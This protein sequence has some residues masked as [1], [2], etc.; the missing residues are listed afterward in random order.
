VPPG[1]KAA[2][3][4]TGPFVVKI[5][6]SALLLAY[7]LRSG[8][9]DGV[10][11]RLAATD[12]GWVWAGFA[13]YAGSHLLN[14]FRWDAYARQFGLV[15]RTSSSIRFYFTGLFLNLFAPGT[16]VGDLSRGIALGRGQRRGVALASVVAHRLTGLVALMAIGGV[17]GLLQRQ[18]ELGWALSLACWAVP[19][20]SVAG[21]FFLPAVLRRGGSLLGREMVLPPAWEAATATTLSLAVIYHCAQILSVICLARALAIGVSMVTLGLFVPL[22]NVAGM[23]PVTVSGVGVR[24][25][26]YVYL[27][28]LIGVSADQALSLGLLGSGLVFATGLVGFPAFVRGR[29]A[30]NRSASD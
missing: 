7:Q 23:V 11:E 29:S 26:G 20:A 18:Y 6:V 14:A 13:L 8:R 22:V 24:E 10:V 17:A 9:A 25:A 1:G 19:S 4:R 12:L 3:G 15:T 30:G 5:L 2:A 21:L 28:G 16:I 27:L